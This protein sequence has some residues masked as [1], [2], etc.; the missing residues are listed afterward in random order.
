MDSEYSALLG[1]YSLRTEPTAERFNTAQRLLAA[2]KELIDHL[3]RRLV[4]AVRR[5]QGEVHVHRARPDIMLPNDARRL[6]TVE[7]R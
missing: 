3:L 1:P 4:R 6:A 5:L 7:H 2:V